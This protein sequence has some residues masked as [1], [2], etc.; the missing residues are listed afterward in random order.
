MK[1]YILCLAMAVGLL[2]SCDGGSSST[3]PNDSN[4]KLTQVHI[5]GNNQSPIMVDDKL[6]YTAIGIESNGTQIDVTAKVKWD[7]DEKLLKPTAPGKFTALQKGIT[8]IAITYPTESGS[9]PIESTIQ[10][11]IKDKPIVTKYTSLRLEGDIE[12]KTAQTGE[13]LVYRA[14]GID[15]NHNTSTDLTRQVSW[16]TREAGAPLKPIANQPGVF[17]VEAG[18]G[19]YT[20]VAS[21]PNSGPPAIESTY[22]IEVINKVIQLNKIKIYPNDLSL[23]YVRNESNDYQLQAKGFDESD[24]EYTLDPELIHWSINPQNAGATIDES[25]GYLHVTDG[26]NFTV[27]AKYNDTL[28]SNARVAVATVNSAV[29]E[30]ELD[31][32]ITLGVPNQI[33]Y[34]SQE[35]ADVKSCPVSSLATIDHSSTNNTV[36]SNHIATLSQCSSYAIPVSSKGTLVYNESY[37]K[38]YTFAKDSKTIYSI[39]TI[40]HQIKS[41][42]VNILGNINDLIISSP[43]TLTVLNSSLKENKLENQVSTCSLDSNGNFIEDSCTTKGFSET[44][45]SGSSLTNSYLI[46]FNDY[47]IIFNPIIRADNDNTALIITRCSTNM[48]SCTKVIDSSDSSSPYFEYKSI[49]IN[50]PSLLTVNNTNFI[51]SIALESEAGIFTPNSL[52]IN[53]DGEI[54]INESNLNV[55]GTPGYSQGND[56]RLY[57]KISFDTQNQWAYY[58]TNNKSN[59]LKKCSYANNQISSNGKITGTCQPVTNFKD[60]FIGVTFVSGKNGNVASS[61]INDLFYITQGF[62]TRLLD[63]FGIV[64]Q[65]SKAGIESIDEDNC[66]KYAIPE[67]INV[68]SKL[69]NNSSLNK[70]Y[71]TNNTN[72]VYVINPIKHQLKAYVTPVSN[73]DAISFNSNGDKVYLAKYDNDYLAITSCDVASDG[74]ITQICSTTI[75]AIGPLTTGIVLN[76]MISYDKYLYIMLGNM[77][78][79][80]SMVANSSDIGQC[81]YLNMLNPKDSANINAD[82]IFT[83]FSGIHKINQDKTFLYLSASK[84]N[85][86]IWPAIIDINNGNLNLNSA[87]LG[88]IKDP[89]LMAKDKGQM[90]SAIEFDNINQYAYLGFPSPSYILTC[91]YDSDIANTGTVNLHGDI[92]NC[93]QVSNFKPFTTLHL[94]YITN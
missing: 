18:T 2:A 38:V 54:V 1:R 86:V 35:S 45:S 3:P 88:D 71:I 20:I 56:L 22:K 69:V 85:D 49:L 14:I 74:A 10:V 76:D 72:V 89:N 78:Y 11:T 61:D 59:F 32:D 53:S 12:K 46:K 67:T 63:L 7:T 41:F 44:P 52:T 40:S 64:A 62:N 4:L 82:K 77:V 68:K 75:N 47:Y 26:T 21:L 5:I 55:L 65:C 73:I 33:F 91:P 23:T 25:S 87:D 79:K 39:D 42:S 34:I 15:A 8:G 30:N 48:D 70:V 50:R 36:E 83:N 94:V 27:I 58:G 16:G 93:N 31:K 9:E 81:Q 57:N 43:N 92:T 6:T 84:I 80:C 24:N 51:Y 90:A 28:E 17:T 37:G 13:T 66:F 29:V 60:S 19:P